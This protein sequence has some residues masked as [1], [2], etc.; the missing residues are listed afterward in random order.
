MYRIGATFSLFYTVQLIFA[1]CDFELSVDFVF[2]HCN[3]N[4]IY[5]FPEKELLGLSHNFHIYVPV[6]D[7]Y[8]SR[9]DPHIF[10]QQNRQ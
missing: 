7:L 8:I 5:V 1:S 4:P 9:L 6:N 2:I 10:L 3:E